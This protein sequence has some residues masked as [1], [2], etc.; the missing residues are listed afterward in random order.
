MT[1]SPSP[2]DFIADL[3]DSVADKIEDA[4]KAAETPKPE[5]GNHTPQRPEEAREV[6]IKNPIAEAQRVLGLAEE[7]AE[8][9][10]NREVKAATL[11]EVA[12]VH[13]EIGKQ[14]LLDF[15]F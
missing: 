13:T 14:L 9:L 2:T 12:K 15:D 7:A 11:I 8:G 3:L 4:L 5:E 1:K 10:A 6:E